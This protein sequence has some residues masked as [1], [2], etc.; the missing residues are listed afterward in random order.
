[1]GASADFAQRYGPWA[2]VAGASEGL[3]AAFADALAA[4]GQNLLL[5][6]RRAGLLADLSERIRSQ[7]AVEVR[8]L[9]LDLGDPGFAASLSEAARD[10][11]VGTIVY[12]AAFSPI[13]RFLERSEQELL[14]VVDVNVRGPVLLLRTL[15]P[16]M[17]ER[18]RGAVVLMSSLAGLQGSPRIATY[19][20]S[21]A[22]D[23]VLAEGLWAELRDCGIDVLACCAGAIRTPAFG[24]SA[25][26]DAPGTLDPAA[27]AEQT[28]DALGRGPRVVPGFVNR[29]AAL[30]NGRL[31]PRRL[32]I[33]VM[34]AN[35][36][37]L[38]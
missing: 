6:A 16:A 25:E 35:T 3:G 1:M 21:K 18:R 7:R 38:T 28:L 26:R 29:L 20:A 2:V 22:F 24:R 30:A 8:T 5:I 19:A 23:T 12:N 27:V 10:L 13:G 34:A 36:R 9:P 33:R 11:A 31:L 15:L 4:R 37:S 14:G 32:A 17:A